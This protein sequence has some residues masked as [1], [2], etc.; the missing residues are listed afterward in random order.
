MKERGRL[1][2]HQRIVRAAHLCTGIRLTPREVTE[3]NYDDAIKTC[4][5]GD[6]EIDGRCGTCLRVKCNCGA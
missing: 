3:L 2:V 6:C 1:T 5:D 4:S